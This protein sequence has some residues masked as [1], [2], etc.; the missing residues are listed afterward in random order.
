MDIEE[1][2]FDVSPFLTIYDHL[3]LFSYI[4]VFFTFHLY[5]F[6]VSIVLEHHYGY[7]W[8]ILGSM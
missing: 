3:D 4:S 6:N 2:I 5:P 8:S 7:P 1:N